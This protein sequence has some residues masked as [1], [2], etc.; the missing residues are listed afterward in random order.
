VREAA[1][2]ALAEIGPPAV[3]ALCAAL[4]SEDPQM[5]LG[6]VAALGQIGDR[7]S[8]RCIVRGLGDPDDGVHDTAARTLVGIGAPAVPEVV[9][10][11]VSDDRRVS[12]RG[13]TMLAEMGDPA[14][15]GLFEALTGERRAIRWAAAKVLVGIGLRDPA[16]VPRLGDM[17]SDQRPE[18]RQAAMRALGE[19]GSDLAIQALVGAMEAEEAA[20]RLQAAEVLVSIGTEGVVLKLRE[21]L[22]RGVDP[23]PIVGILSRSE[24]R[25]ARHFLRDLLQSEDKVVRDMAAFALEADERSGL[26][27]YRAWEQTIEERL[28]SRGTVSTALLSETPSELRSVVLQRYISNHPEMDLSYDAEMAILQLNAIARYERVVECWDRATQNL[29]GDSGLSGQMFAECVRGLITVLCEILGVTIAG[30]EIHERLHCFVLQ[31]S[32]VIR[33]TNLPQEIPLVFLQRDTLTEGDLTDLRELLATI[34][35]LHR[36]ALLVLFANRGH[37]LRA[38]QLVDEK[39]RDV[40]AFD[41]IVLGAEE[42]Q[43]VATA[44]SP[45]D[46]LRYVICEQADLTLVSPY[47]FDEPASRM[48]FFGREFEIRSITQTIPNSSVAVLGGRRIGK[49]SI[50]HR[51]A[52]L[53]RETYSCHYMDCH[54][55]RDYDTL[56]RTMQYRWPS[57]GSLAPE[58]VNFHSIVSK[59]AGDGPLVLVLDE[60]DALLRFDIENDELLFKTFRSLS[61]EGVCRFIFSGERVLSNQLKYGVTSPLFNF[62]GQRIRLGYLEPRSAEQLIVEPMGWMNIEIR[63]SDRVVEGILDLSSCHPRLVQYICH[64]LIKQINQQGVRFVSRQHLQRIARSNE[65]HEEYLW[66]VWGDAT[67]FER[68]LTLALEQVAV[69]VHGIQAALE[70]WDI[71]HTWEGL[72]SALHSLEICSVLEQDGDTYHFVAEHFP[73]IARQSLDVEMEISVLRRKIRGER[74]L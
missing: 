44:K 61:Q 5:R 1:V 32:T 52:D 38:Q 3:G 71:P 43:R 48:L 66:T 23:E 8:V 31:V 73:R 65:L 7:E 72:A 26:Y 47:S 11:L 4:E 37:V 15:D 60:I 46:A 6:V 12:E 69:T 67:V 62:C 34:G 56:F 39:L 50:L 68:A 20:V 30:T 49:T 22:D 14:V 58:P 64:S 17:L 55:I 70:R 54:A 41:V 45:P 36:T 33:G 13:A 19:I 16:V 2:A 53:L 57:I 63:E 74:N 24:T 28:L 9:E 18:V 29:D 27:Y 10:A 59:V 51:V 35:V 21:A 42:L 25:S 40:H